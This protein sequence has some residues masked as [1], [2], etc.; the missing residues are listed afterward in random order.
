[1]PGSIVSNDNESIV[2]GH[3]SIESYQNE[4]R[5]DAVMDQLPSKL[6]KQL[7]LSPFRSQIFELVQTDLYNKA[8]LLVIT[9]QLIIL[10]VRT[11]N[12]AN[13]QWSY[14]L[15]VFD[16][17]IL[18]GYLYDIV[19]KIFAWQRYFFTYPTNSFDAVILICDLIVL[20]VPQ[21]V[22]KQDSSFDLAI[23]LLTT[24]RTLRILK[25]IS[26]IKALSIIVSTLLKSSRSM[27]SIVMLMVLF[28]YVFSVI[29]T[30]SFRAYDPNRFGSLGTS[31][32]TLFSMLSID[33]YISWS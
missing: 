27:L 1:M 4:K 23:K 20:I 11:V 12:E 17:L 28:L 18:G 7:L 15:D 16:S 21:L 13:R 9:L 2:S 26:H 29:A 31:F 5:F 22:Q 8:F 10:T 19:L 3:K 24:A 14:M 25:S 33:K 32:F 30:T 6:A